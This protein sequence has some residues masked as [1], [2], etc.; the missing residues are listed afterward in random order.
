MDA[1][2]LAKMKHGGVEVLHCEQL[3]Q[4]FLWLP[5]GYLVVEKVPDGVDALGVCKCV[6]VLGEKPVVAMK[7]ARSL[8]KNDGVA[9]GK[10]DQIIATME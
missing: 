1:D 3:P 10:L 4:T 2:R 7:V 8:V 5:H 9:T 6:F